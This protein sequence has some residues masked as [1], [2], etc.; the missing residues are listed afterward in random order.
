MAFVFRLSEIAERVAPAPYTRY[1]KAVF[2]HNSIAETPLSIGYFRLEPGQSG[3]KHL[4]ENEVEVYIVLQGNGKVTVGEEAVALH[5]GTVVYVP[6]EIEH[7]TINTGTCDL[8]FYGV[9]SPCLDFTAMKS[10][11][12]AAEEGKK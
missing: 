1:A 12:K 2:D 4:H 5:P 11:P 10:W 6:P 7:Q 9:F 3:P 8:E